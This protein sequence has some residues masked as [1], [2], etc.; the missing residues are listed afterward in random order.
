MG[1]PRARADGA[2]MLTASLHSALP[3]PAADGSL[4][5]WL[6]LVPAGTFRGADGRGPYTLA[7]AEALIAAS[8]A[9]GPLVLDENHAT[10][11]ALK[12]GQPAPAQGWIVELQARPD[13]IWGR[14]EWTP[15]GQ[16]LMAA[17]AYRGVSP[18]FAHNKAGRVLQLLRA[19]LTNAPNLPQLHTLHTQEPEMDASKLREALGLP[20]DADEAAILA[21]VTTARQSQQAAATLQTQVAGMADQ[22]VALQAQVDAAAL[23]GRRAAAERAVDAAITAGKPVKPVRDYFIEL[24]MADPAKAAE[25]LDK[26]PSL[27]A[28]GATPPKAQGAAGAD[29]LDAAEREVIAL[30]GLDEA[31]FKETKAKLGQTVEAV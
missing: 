16:A 28:G 26:M 6:H 8:M 15:A 21:A 3:A 24:H 11:H 17:R 5:D 9:G 14:V 31:A 22:V 23:A 29:G 25:A 27:H 19:A 2:G 12:S 13:G 18:V 4:P 20:A 7:S 1:S 30:M 10:D